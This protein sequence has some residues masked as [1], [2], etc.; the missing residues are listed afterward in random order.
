MSP[1]F[2]LY[3][4]ANHQAIDEL[5]IKPHHKKVTRSPG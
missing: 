3:N 4:E 1:F 2:I 5:H